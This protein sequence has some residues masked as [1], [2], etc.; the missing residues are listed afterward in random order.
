MVGALHRRVEE[1]DVLGARAAEEAMAP[2]PAVYDI[3]V[4]GVV[5]LAV[6]HGPLLDPGEASADGAAG[7]GERAE[8]LGHPGQHPKDVERV[9]RQERS[10]PEHGREQGADRRRAGLVV[11]DRADRDIGGAAQAHHVVDGV[12]RAVSAVADAI[13][14]IRCDLRDALVRPEPGDEVQDVLPDRAVAAE[15][16]VGQ[17]AVPASQ[18]P[19]VAGADL[20]KGGQGR[21]LHRVGRCASSSSAG[22]C[23]FCLALFAVAFLGRLYRRRANGRR[24][25]GPVKAQVVALFEDGLELLLVAAEEICQV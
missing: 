16:V 7:V 10:G 11:G 18:A 21:L 22:L 24:H 8:H 19:D 25:L 1:Q 23:N 17:P 4:P 14:R 9:D 2:L 15:Q 3:L 6:H 13:R 20:A 12:D 5:V